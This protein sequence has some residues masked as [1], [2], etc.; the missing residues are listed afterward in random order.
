MP[1]VV[2]STL[3]IFTTSA[4]IALEGR[5]RH[6]QCDGDQGFAAHAEVLRS[7]PIKR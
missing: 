2:G 5:E 4:A 6:R 7:G 3:P 1:P